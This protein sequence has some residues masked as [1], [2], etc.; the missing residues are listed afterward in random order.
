MLKKINNTVFYTFCCKYSCLDIIVVCLANVGRR[1]SSGGG[2][3]VRGGSGDGGG[4]GSCV[5]WGLG[6]AA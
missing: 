3:S 1:W 2:D 4:G 6:W 5:R